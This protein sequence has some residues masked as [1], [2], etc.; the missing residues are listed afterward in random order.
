MPF[1][2]TLFIKTRV[3]PAVER[4]TRATKQS[5]VSRMNTCR[6]A[7]NLRLELTLSRLALS[8]QHFF[9]SG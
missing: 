6:G 2:A 8:S 4:C 3:A 7:L 9:R 1:D 5:A